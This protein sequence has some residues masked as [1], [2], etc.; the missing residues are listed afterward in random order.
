ME[1]ETSSEPAPTS[2]DALGPSAFVASAQ[3]AALASRDSQT[4]TPTVAGAFG[5]VSRMLL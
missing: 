2:V 3:A 4:Q 5:C 1:L